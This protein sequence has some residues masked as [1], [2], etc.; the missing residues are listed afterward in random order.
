[1]SNFYAQYRS[2]EPFLKRKN[3]EIKY[4]EQQFFQS[5]E[6]RSKLVIKFINDL[7]VIKLINYLLIRMAYM[8]VFYVLVV[9]LRVHLIGGTLI[10]ISGSTSVFSHHLKS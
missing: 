8:N 4:G 1:M 3:T 6:D 5:Q 10:N 2:I 7:A 9:Q